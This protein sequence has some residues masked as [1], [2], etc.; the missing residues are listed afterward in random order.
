MPQIAKKEKNL[1]RQHEEGNGV[2]APCKAL[3]K[4]NGDNSINTAAFFS[5]L[6]LLVSNLL[7]F[8]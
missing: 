7:E 3:S 2:V 5:F 8:Y 4:G 1:T 6:P